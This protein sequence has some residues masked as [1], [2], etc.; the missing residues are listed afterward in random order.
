MGNIK[1]KNIGTVYVP[2]SYSGNGPY[3]S[4]LTLEKTTAYNNLFIIY[5]KPK[6]KINITNCNT[7]NISIKL[8]N[9][10]LNF[11]IFIEKSNNIIKKNNHTT[12]FEKFTKYHSDIDTDFLYENNHYIYVNKKN[13]IKEIVC[14][15]KNNII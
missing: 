5:L 8:K 10:Y 15:T 11:N 6:K 3:T 1:S 7:I 4:K 13:Q 14:I 2:S 12:G 9:E